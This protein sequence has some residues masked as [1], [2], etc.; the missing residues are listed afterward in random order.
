M[1]AR[2]KNIYLQHDPVSLSTLTDTSSIQLNENI[3]AAEIGNDFVAETPSSYQFQLRSIDLAKLLQIR[4][5][6]TKKKEK[7]VYLMNLVL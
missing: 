7:W 1:I 5:G 6:K 3:S 2:Y 4:A